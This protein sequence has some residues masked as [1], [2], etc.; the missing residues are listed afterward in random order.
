MARLLQVAPGAVTSL[1]A[2]NAPRGA[3][4]LVFDESFA[5]GRIAV[6]RLRNTATV[7]LDFAVL[8]GWLNDLAIR[9]TVMKLP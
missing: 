9:P 4:R 6:H 2:V 8:L 3:L 1:A 7:A 5:G